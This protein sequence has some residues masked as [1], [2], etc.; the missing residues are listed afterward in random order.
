LKNDFSVVSVDS[1]TE[2]KIIAN[3]NACSS[4][5]KAILLSTVLLDISPICGFSEEIRNN[6]AFVKAVFVDIESLIF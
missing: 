4:K 6:S 3:Y 5:R 2:R 1:F